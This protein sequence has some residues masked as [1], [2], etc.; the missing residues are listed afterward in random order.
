MLLLA[1]HPG[2]APFWWA[3]LLRIWPCHWI[4]DAT[5]IAPDSFPPEQR[6]R[7][8]TPERMLRGDYGFLV[9]I[10]TA[11]RFTRTTYLCLCYLFCVMSSWFL[12]NLSLI[13]RSWWQWWG[14]WMLP[15]LLQAAVMCWLRW[16]PAP[17]FCLVW[18]CSW[19]FCLLIAWVDTHF[20]PGE[21]HFYP[22]LMWWSG[23]LP[24]TFV[25]LTWCS[26]HLFLEIYPDLQDRAAE[27]HRPIQREKKISGTFFGTFSGTLSSPE[28]SP[29]L[30]WTWPGA[31]TSAH[32]SY[33][34]QKIPLAY[35]VF[36]LECRFCSRARSF[37]WEIKV[38][39][40]GHKSSQK[41]CTQ[42]GG[43]IRQAKPEPSVG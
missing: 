11:C 36:F 8:R 40:R 26:H 9:C 15:S 33:S 18:L 32:Q 6:T 4:D 20:W 14:C 12:N 22:T 29:E 5:V 3:A 16:A 1:P 27:L 35:A 28:P 24:P 43:T 31:C 38:V 34:R 13:E 23:F 37:V 10:L 39:K 17:F 41:V 25:Q 2:A 30:R 21:M 42:A 7:Q 19:F